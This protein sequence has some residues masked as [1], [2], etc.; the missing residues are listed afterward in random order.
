MGILQGIKETNVDAF[1]IILD[2]SPEYPEYSG[3]I[4]A[5]AVANASDTD[6]SA[7]VTFRIKTTTDGQPP[8]NVMIYIEGCDSLKLRTKAQI[9]ERP[10][11][12]RSGLVIIEGFCCFIGFTL[13][14]ANWCPITN[15]MQP[16][17]MAEYYSPDALSDLSNAYENRNG[18]SFP[19]SQ[20]PMIRAYFNAPVSISA[21]A[22]QP[23]YKNRETNIIKYS[24]YYVT[25]DD[26]PYIDPATGEILRLTTSDGDT[27]LTIQHD[28]INNLKGLVLTINQTSGGRPSWFRLKVLGCYKPSELFL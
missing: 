23:S 28:L 15:I 26:K 14:L 6:R 1:D 4:G 24:L 20:T 7:S 16:E 18:V 3:R 2:H 12:T 13:L 19:L 10:S 9:E 17:N 25:L 27:S 5:L 8:R 11:T 22:L 21:V